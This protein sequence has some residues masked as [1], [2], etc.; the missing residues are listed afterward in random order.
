MLKHYKKDTN[1]IQIRRKSINTKWRIN[2]VLVFLYAF[3][4]TKDPASKQIHA[5]VNVFL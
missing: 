1:F 3:P 4:V 5:S 2:Q